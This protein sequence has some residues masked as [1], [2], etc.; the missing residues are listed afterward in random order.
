LWP[1]IEATPNHQ[2]LTYEITAH[3]LRQ[4]SAGNVS[5]GAIAEQQYR[6]L[7]VETVAFLDLCAKRAGVTWITPVEQVARF[8]LAFMN[9]LVLRW[10]VDGDSDAALSA[11]DDLVQI[12][13]TKAR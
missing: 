10:L 4:R 11:L 7:D 6:T 5:A 1:I 12:L 9:G 13:T 2:L 3:A 8:V